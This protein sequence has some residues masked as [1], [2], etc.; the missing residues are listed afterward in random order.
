M[1]TTWMV[2]LTIVLLTVTAYGDTY[3][4]QS[5]D[6]LSK[7]A[8][9]ELGDSA[10][11]K[12]IAELNDLKE[13]YSLNVGQQLE[14]PVESSNTLTVEPRSH[15]GQDRTTP[16]SED[17]SDDMSELDIFSDLQILPFLFSNVTLSKAIIIPVIIIHLILGIFFLGVG[18]RFTASAVNIE[19]TLQRCLIAAMSVSL[20]ILIPI[21]LVLLAC[22]TN[23]LTWSPSLLLLSPLL[24]GLGYVFLAMCILRSC[25]QCRWGISFIV[26]FLGGII[27]PAFYNA[28]MY[29]IALLVWLIVFVIGGITLL[30]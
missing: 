27:G 10:R 28:V 25:L 13:P 26:G 8:Q 22:W 29:I 24:L 19:T 11:W 9:A 12:E 30:F 2:L 7:I 21:G 14:L 18:Y 17:I 3:T 15:D 5:G 23:P 4:V 1:K 6:T 20:S 16:A